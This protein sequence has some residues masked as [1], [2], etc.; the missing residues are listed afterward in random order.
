MTSAPPNLGRDLRVLFIHGLEGSPEGA[1]AVYLAERFAAHT[2]RMQTADFPRCVELQ[3]RML[4]DHVPHVVVGS[5][6]GGAVAL[7][8]LQSGAW[9]GPTLLLAPAID[10]FGVSPELPENADVTVVHGTGDTVV[11]IVSSRRLVQSAKSKRAR[12]LEVDDTHRL[13][14]LTS[15]EKLADLVRELAR[16]AA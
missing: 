8:L 1:K 15:G 12:L 9:A 7:T 13:E 14:S 11:S 5:S 2:P 6:F 4:R 3:K 16:V 10:A